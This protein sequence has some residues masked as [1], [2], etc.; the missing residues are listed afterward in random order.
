MQSPRNIASYQDLSSFPP[1]L[2]FRQM[3]FQLIGEAV[4]Q[5]AEPLLVVIRQ[6]QM[7]E[8]SL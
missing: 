7:Q 8:N 4:E 5:L 3:L 2:R 1:P 6:I